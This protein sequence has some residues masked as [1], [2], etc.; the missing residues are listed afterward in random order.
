MIHALTKN[1]KWDNPLKIGLIAFFSSLYFYLPILTI[2]YQRRGLNYFQINS[3]TGIIIGTIFLAELPT[4][5][6]ADKLG[7]KASIL[8]GLALQ[9][10]G[11]VLFLFAGGYLNFVMISIIAGLGFAF[12]SGCTQALV[13]DSLKEQGEEKNAKKVLGNIGAF[14]QLAHLLGAGISTLII[15]QLTTQRI[16]LAIIL[17]IFSVAVSLIVST[18]LKEPKILYTHPEENPLKI[19]KKSFSILKN[20][21]SLRRIVLMGTFTTPFIM[22]LQNFQPP[23]FSLSH[24][25]VVWL[26]PA[27][28]GGGII[29]MLSSKYAYKLE[30]LVGAKNAMLIS[31]FIPGVFYILMSIIYL[32]SISILLFS[33]NFGLMS[34]QDPLLADYQNAHISSEIRATALSLISMLSSAYI[35]IMGLVIGKIADISIPYAFLFMGAVAVFGSILFR[36][37]K[38]HLATTRA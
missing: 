12:Q 2:Y 18:T 5:V 9:L 24:L 4:G 30:S 19:L 7:R 33:F 13:Y 32:P 37:N 15:F 8:I 3:L 1:L 26:G 29:A 38:T 28:V 35:S 23:Y 17:T 10:L 6:I 21:L 20:N 36:I 31:T 11:E 34:L 27:L 25:P 14:Y 16:A 22:Y